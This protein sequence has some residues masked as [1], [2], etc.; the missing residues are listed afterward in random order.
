M[1]S[2]HFLMVLTSMVMM[3]FFL[4]LTGQRCPVPSGIFTCS[5]VILDGIFRNG[6]SNRVSLLGL[7]D[8]YHQSLKKG[9][10]YIL[11][12]HGQGDRIEPILF[13]FSVSGHRFRVYK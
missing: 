6:S 7:L 5:L 1:N 8:R 11:T 9:W 10:N 3:A 12:V 2:S 13:A 4:W